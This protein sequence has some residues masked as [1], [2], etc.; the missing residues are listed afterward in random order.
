MVYMSAPRHYEADTP[1]VVLSPVD[2]PN[3][4]ELPLDGRSTHEQPDDSLD[5][6]PPITD[7]LNVLRLAKGGDDEALNRLCARYLP[8]LHRLATRKLPPEA[9][10]MVET[11]DIAQE[12]LSNAVRRLDGA[13][14]ENA[15]DFQAYLRRAVV[16]R[17]VD[18]AR[19]VRRHG[20]HV[21]HEDRS[22][23]NAPSPLDR[24]LREDALDR[25]EQAL[26]RLRPEDRLAIQTR[27]ELELS[28]EEVAEALGKPSADA[29]RKA[30]GRALEAL[31]REWKKRNREP[32]TV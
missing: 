19:R 3:P 21:E 31:K 24:V 9:R 23:D 32:D 10:G 4:E 11:V 13:H 7:T 22:P 25:Y 17:V 5:P 20:P 14:F 30:V 29:A 1:E 8:R 26:E 27:I 6:T 12:V 2:R 15:G 28:Y 18:E 16:N